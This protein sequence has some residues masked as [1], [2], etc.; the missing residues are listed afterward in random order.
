MHSVAHSFSV[1]CVCGL[2]FNGFRLRE[3]VVTITKDALQKPKRWINRIEYICIHVNMNITRFLTLLLQN[4]SIFPFMNAICNSINFSILHIY[5][6]CA[7][8]PNGLRSANSLSLCNK[9]Y[10][11]IFSI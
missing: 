5:F 4:M 7:R 8:Y 3:L 6:M 1:K 9:I 2:F 11:H 10:I